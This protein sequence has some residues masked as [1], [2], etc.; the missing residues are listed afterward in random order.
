MKFDSNLAWK[1]AAASVSANREVLLAMAGVFF[2]LPGLALNLFMPQPVLSTDMGEEAAAAVMR[3]YYLSILPFAIPMALVQAAGTLGMLTLFTDR[4]RPT[5]GQAIRQGVAGILP[6]LLSQLILGFG[7][8]IAGGVLLAIGMITGSMALRTFAIA[9]AVLLALCA[10]IRSSL[11]APVIAVEGE[12]NPIAAL[13]R[14]WQ[15]TKGNSL[16]IA[17]FYFLVL[18]AFAIVI[19]AL[20]AVL[21]AVLAFMLAAKEREMVIML[22][23]SV[24]GTGVTLYFVAILAAIHRQLAGPSPEAASALFE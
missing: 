2:L 22:F 9:A 10:A 23:S 24:L 13:K 17:L 16:R 4:S 19:T 7:I 11:T 14:S 21:G 20:M 6:Y 8:G 5:V 1:Q 3:D 18:L 12:R 15:L